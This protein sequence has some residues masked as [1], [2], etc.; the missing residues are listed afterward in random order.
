MVTLSDASSAVIVAIDPANPYAPKVRKLERGLV[1]TGDA[2]DVNTP[3]QP[4]I[5]IAE[6]EPTD[7]LLP[8]N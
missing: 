5:V 1:L 2:F 3:G 7:G 6:G 4:A 8:V